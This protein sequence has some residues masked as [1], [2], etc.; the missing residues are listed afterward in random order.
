VQIDSIEPWSQVNN[1]QNEQNNDQNGKNALLLKLTDGV[2]SVQAI[3][4]DSIP[5]LK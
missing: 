3:A 5:N 4:D 1:N 2:I